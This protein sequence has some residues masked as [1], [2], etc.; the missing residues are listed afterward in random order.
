MGDWEEKSL[1]QA[2]RSMAKN[3]Q[4]VQIAHLVWDKEPGSE[5]LALGLSSCWRWCKSATGLLCA[6]LSWCSKSDRVSHSSLLYLGWHTHT[7]PVVQAHARLLRR[8]QF[9]FHL[10]RSCQ[11]IRFKQKMPI[12]RRK[13]CFHDSHPRRLEKGPYWAP[14]ISN[15]IWAP[16]WCQACYG[17]IKRVS[18]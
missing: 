14:I 4:C 11:G 15:P 1:P 12:C 10:I 8:H 7:E 2:L 3:F 17:L 13:I 9:R 16:L 5:A 18:L 6:L